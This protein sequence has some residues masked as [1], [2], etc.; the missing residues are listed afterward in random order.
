MTTGRR[1]L[2]VSGQVAWDAE[3][4]LVGGSSVALQAQQAFRNLKAVLDQAGAS[5]SDVAALRIYIV[6]YEP[7]LAGEV[8]GAFR[9]FFSPEAAPATT[10]V[11]V[12][13]LADPDLLIEIEA[14]AVLD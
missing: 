12:A 1:T 6:D 3:R 9:A 10:W 13:A 2:Y 7:E 14:V 11:G 4:R 8:G 5:P